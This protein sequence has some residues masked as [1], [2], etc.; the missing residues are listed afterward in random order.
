MDYSLNLPGIKLISDRD[1]VE[2]TAYI[3]VKSTSKI[4]VES[5]LKIRAE[6]NATMGCLLKVLTLWDH[7]HRHFLA[8]DVGYD[9]ALPMLDVILSMISCSEK[10][11]NSTWYF[12]FHFF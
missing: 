12:I 5:T 10:T 7:V 6:T 1:D 9:H 8:T 4:N 2:S 3:N 11:F